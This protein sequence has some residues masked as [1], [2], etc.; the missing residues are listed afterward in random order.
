MGRFK[1][2]VCD[3]KIARRAVDEELS[4]G[5]SYAAVARLMTLRGFPVTDKTVG[6]HKQHAVPLP[7]PGVATQKRDAAVMLLD[8]MVSAVERLPE[9]S[10]G[11][12]DPILDRRLQ[13]ALQTALKA[14][15][16]LDRREARVDDRKAT[17]QLHVLLAGG[18]AGLLAPPDLTDS[19]TDDDDTII[20]GEAVEVDV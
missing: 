10:E 2:K 7:P 8:R 15:A 12:P 17:L 9:P 5:L 13:P 14:Q 3:D 1:C 18:P 4:K 19:E 6:E 11:E 16:L 20:E